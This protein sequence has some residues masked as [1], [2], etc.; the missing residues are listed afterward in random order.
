MNK[1]PRWLY[2]RYEKR[3]DKAQRGR[4]TGHGIFLVTP[5]NAVHVQ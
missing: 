2:D 3:G 4:Q 1:I 5:R